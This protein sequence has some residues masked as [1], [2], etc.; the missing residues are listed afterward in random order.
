[1]YTHVKEYIHKESRTP[2]FILSGVFNFTADGALLD[3][4][5][6]FPGLKVGKIYYPFIFF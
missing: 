4:W 2:F 6:K 5:S 1:M 3:A